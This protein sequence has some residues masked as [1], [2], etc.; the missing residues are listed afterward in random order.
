MVKAVF[1]RPMKLQSWFKNSKWGL[2]SG[3][4]GIFVNVKL[5]FFLSFFFFLTLLYLSVPWSSFFF[6]FSLKKELVYSK[7]GVGGVGVCV[8]FCF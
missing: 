2:G 7:I 6:F 5:F 8:Y 1:L 4:G 3:L